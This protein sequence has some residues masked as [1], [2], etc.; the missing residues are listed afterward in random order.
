MSTLQFLFDT[1]HSLR[2]CRRRRRRLRLLA[3]TTSSSPAA[4]GLP[5]A[6]SRMIAAFRPFDL[7]VKLRA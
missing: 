5:P 7:S 6:Y 1:S 3:L 4:L 2:P